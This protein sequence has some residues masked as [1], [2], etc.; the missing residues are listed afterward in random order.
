MVVAAKG[1]SA[2]EPAE[3]AAEQAHDEAYRRQQSRHAD[4]T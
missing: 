3:E 4:A 1:P 2:E